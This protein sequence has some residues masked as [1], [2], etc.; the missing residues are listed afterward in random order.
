MRLV[1]GRHR[2]RSSEAT[3]NYIRN[4][5]AEALTRPGR[6]I[7]L[8]L[9]PPPAPAAAQA[10]A[11]RQVGGSRIGANMRQERGEDPEKQAPISTKV[12]RV[13]TFCRVCEPS[14][15]LV[16]E[17]QDGRII[18]VQG[19]PEHVSSHGHFCKKAMGA[20]EVTYDPDR[21]LRPLK[22]TGAPGEFEPISWPQAMREIG[23]RLARIRKD[24]GPAAFATFL[25]QPPTNTYS[26]AMWYPV[27]KKVLGTKWN[28]AVNAEDSAAYMRAC[29]ILYGSVSILPKPDFWRTDFAIIIGANPLVSHGSLCGEPQMRK[30]L[31]EIVARGGRVVVI[32]PRRTETAQLFEHIGVNAGSDA[33]LLL[34]MLREILLEGL[35]DENFVASE[36]RNVAA[37]REQVEPFTPELAAARCGVS[38]STIRTLARDFAGAPSA[39]IYGRTGTCTQQFGTLINLL[40]NLLCLVTGNVD[41]VGGM[42]IP[43]SP[44][45]GNPTVSGGPAADPLR[46]RTTGLPAVAGYMPSRALVTDITEPGP[47]KVRALMMIGANPLSS[48]AA[49]GTAYAGALEQLELFFSLDLYVT[50]TNKHAHYILPVTTMYEHEDLPFKYLFAQLRPAMWATPAVV[51]PRGEARDDWRIMN[52]ICRRVGVGGAYESRLLRFLSAAGWAVKPATL[53]DRMIRRSGPGRKHRLSLRRLLGEFRQGVALGDGLPVG[54]L[55][56]R[57]DP[58]DLAPEDLAGEIRRLSQQEADPAYPYRL[59]GMREVLSQNTWMHNVPSLM[60]AHR[61]HHLHISP[62]DAAELQLGDGDE[63]EVTSSAGKSPTSYVIY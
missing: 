40:Q 22:R 23:H 63:V 39:L 11:P 32:D 15:G 2:T 42:V 48:S 37:L 43:A 61:K 9:D 41:R 21:V 18:S 7:S 52:E 28:Y 51:A 53:V 38:P 62:T 49:T 57:P 16:A 4:F 3:L 8:A 56:S 30:C 17:V 24:H 45:G 31:K 55:S 50:E 14:C 44:L 35:I 60:S 27:F 36:T 25:G 20:V 59:I 33:W 1:R 46:S 29:E 26:T 19:D 6:A 12:E 13:L 34:A 5:N 10:A 47:E 58:I 54:L